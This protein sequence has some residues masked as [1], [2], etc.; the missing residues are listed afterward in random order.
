MPPEHSSRKHVRS[1]PVAR[2]DFAWSP[3]QE[4]RAA[5][6]KRIKAHAQAELDRIWDQ[7]LLDG[8]LERRR[9]SPVY[10]RNRRLFGH[11]LDGVGVAEF[12]LAYGLRAYQVRDIIAPARGL[13]PP[14]ACRPPVHFR[15]N[16]AT[17]SP[18]G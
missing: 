8:R 14:R 18:V 7:H 3:A 9:A 17:A 13:V 4:S 5:F 12:G 6:W 15:A 16:G 10:E 11:H 2:T 1:Y